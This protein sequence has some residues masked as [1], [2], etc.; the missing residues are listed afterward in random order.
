M[1]K[2]VDWFAGAEPQTAEGA[3]AL[4]G[5]YRTLEAARRRPPDSPHLAR[6]ELRGR[7]PA[8]DAV[9]VRSDALRRRP[10]PPRRHDALWRPGACG[11]RSG[12]PPPGRPATAGRGALA[13]RANAANANDLGS[14]CRPASR[15]AWP[16]SGPPTCAAGASTP[17]RL[18][19][20]RTSPRRRPRRSWPT[21][22]GT[23]A[24]SSAAGHPQRRF[25]AYAAA[26]N[27][28]LTSGGDAAD[29]EFYAGWI[30]LRRLKDPARRRPLRGPGE[31]RL[32]AHHPRP[33]PLLA[34][35]GGRGPRRPAQGAGVLRQGRPVLHHLLRPAG[36]RAGRRR[37]PHP[38]AGP[39]DHPRRPRPLRGPRH[40]ARRPAAVRDPATAICSA[41]WSWASTTSCPPPR[42][43]PCWSTWP[44]ATASRTPP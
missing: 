5:A 1:A 24:T 31:D 27:S 34:G 18:A 33:R 23:S 29:A 20:C 43:K 4:A 35:P 42:R 44:A 26:A 30:A 38:A 40:G 15:P 39:G 10:R 2:I 16:S 8:P 32:L 17:W 13:L 22:S 7:R 19:C 12:R 36:R 6:E 3:M 9:A 11:P 14:P 25:P 37:P 21:A 41:P 28:G